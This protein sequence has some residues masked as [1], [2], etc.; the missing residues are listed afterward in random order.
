MIIPVSIIM[1]NTASRYEYRP[2]QPGESTIVKINLSKDKQLTGK[3][4]EVKLSVPE[5]LRI[6]TPPLRIGGRQGSILE[7]QGREG[8]CI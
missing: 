1:I 6:E 3:N 2:L 8:R 4:H 5:G 7:N